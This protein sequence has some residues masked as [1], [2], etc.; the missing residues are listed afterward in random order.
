MPV[1]SRLQSILAAGPQ[2]Q[3]VS[4]EQ[5]I[6]MRTV[7]HQLAEQLLPLLIDSG[8]PMASVDEDRIPVQAGEIDVRIYRPVDA[9]SLPM[10]VYLHGGGWWQ[11]NLALVDAECRYMAKSSE[12]VVASVA[13]RLAPEHRFPV[14]L[15][16][17]Y[18][19]LQWATKHAGRLGIDPGRIAVAGGSAGGNLAASVTLLAR[20]RGGPDLQAQVLVV[21]A[22][23]LTWSFP[24]IADYSRDYGLTNAQLEFSARVYIGPDGD[25]RIPLVSPINADLHDLP[26][27]LIITAECDPLRDEGEEYGRRLRDAGVPATV[28]RVPG[29][30]HGTF[31]FNQLVPDVADRYFEEIGSFLVRALRKPMAATAAPS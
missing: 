15:E 30:L 31:V 25:P 20:D 28:H 27:A 6:E 10:C 11:G 19:G 9:E 3:P 22:T 26:P 12:C 17:C 16:D 8:P 29:M 18:A 21:P 2:P 4:D 24:S 14:P 5:A 23:D 1:D 7:S 13:Y